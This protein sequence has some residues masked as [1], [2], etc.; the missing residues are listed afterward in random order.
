LRRALGRHFKNP[1]LQPFC[2]ALLAG[3]IGGIAVRYQLSSS[4][5]LVAV[6]PCMILFPGPHVLNAAADLLRGRV[7]LGW[8][9]LVF[10]GVVLSAIA[11]GLLLGLALLGTSLPL[12]PAGRSVSLWEDV[13]ASA[14]AVFAYS[15]F[16]STPLR[17]LTAPIAIGALAHALRWITLSVFDLNIAI[18]ALVAA[19]F[20]GIVLTPVAR[21]MRIPFAPIG[22][23][24]VVSMI[25]GV[26]LFR[27]AS[28]LVALADGSHTTF[29][30]LAATI[31]DTMTAVNILV[32]LSAGLI[33]PNLIIDRL[34]QRSYER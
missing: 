10:S 15:V 1:F 9:R 33:V 24:C 28:G 2:A 32:A 29:A 12:D 20:V 13:V 6:T 8:A 14:V 23:A 25:P 18:G 27:M 5:R 26:Y 4:L 31:A 3:I 7:P 19:A 30:L 17:L 22:F 21:R 34:W 11:T 16:Y